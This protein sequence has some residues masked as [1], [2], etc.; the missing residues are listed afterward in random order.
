[1]TFLGFLTLFDP[2]KANIL[3]TIKSLKNL[4]VS[5]KIITGDNHLVATSLSKKWDCP[6][7]KISPG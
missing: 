2:P 3:E 1:M 6:I 7:N 5:L 4:G